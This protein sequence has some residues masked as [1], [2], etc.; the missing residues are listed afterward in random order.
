MN[1]SRAL[2]TTVQDLPVSF[3]FQI[4]DDFN[5]AAVK[6]TLI[7]EIVYNSRYFDEV[8]V[9]PDSL[10]V[11]ESPSQDGFKIFTVKKSA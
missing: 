8:S 2:E 1:E 11:E 4:S 3:T 6:K 10:V 9:D 5:E 7:S